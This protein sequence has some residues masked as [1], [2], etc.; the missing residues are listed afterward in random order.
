[1]RNGGDRE[2]NRIYPWDR[3]FSTLRTFFYESTNYDW[4]E[5]V[6][7]HTDSKKR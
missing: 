4:N 1:M 7:S 2:S 5:N 6:M 3:L